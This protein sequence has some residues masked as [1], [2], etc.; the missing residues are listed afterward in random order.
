VLVDEL[1]EAL[2]RRG[3]DKLGCVKRRLC[4]DGMVL[5]GW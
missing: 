5:G 4:A 3:P 2:R 1:K